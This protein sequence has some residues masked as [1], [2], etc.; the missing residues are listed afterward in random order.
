MNRIHWRRECTEKL[1]NLQVCATAALS[2]IWF[3][4]DVPRVISMLPKDFQGLQPVSQWVATALKPYETIATLIKQIA[5]VFDLPDRWLAVRATELKKEKNRW[6]RLS[7]VTNAVQTTFDAA[8]LIPNSWK[9]INLA[10][11]SSLVGTTPFVL[12][13]L[14]EGFTILTAFCRVKAAVI[15]Q[16]NA[17]MRIQN[18]KKRLDASTPLLELKRE[19]SGNSPSLDTINRLKMAY[20]SKDKTE[21]V[22]GLKREIAALQKERRDNLW[23]DCDKKI[24]AKREK[25]A[26]L[27]VWQTP[28]KANELDRL[29]AV[30]NYK[31]KKGEVK[32][33][34]IQ[35]EKK[36]I[37]A[38]S[39]Y[40]ASKMIV[41]T[42]S[43][44]L[45]LGVALAVAPLLGLPVATVAGLFFLGR[46]ITSL[47]TGIFCVGK[48]VDFTRYKEP[49]QLPQTHLVKV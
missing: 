16:K 27:T 42:F 3:G 22:F 7:L 36:I 28:T 23:V 31:I 45:H 5:T 4:M 26:R 20:Q 13:R 29:L 10:R 46:W 48:I 49:L 17:D 37:A 11:W 33:A 14:K 44:L 6:T 47:T 19:L 15:D 12:E 38:G 1:G 40:E 25:L 30:V 21:I 2:F 8:L 39:R 34:N 18:I 35:G 24:I 41:L 32:I 43:N 9:M